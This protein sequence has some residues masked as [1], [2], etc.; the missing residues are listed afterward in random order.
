MRMKT[1]DFR[2]ATIAILLSAEAIVHAAELKVGDSAP[3]LQVAQWVQG[4]PIQNGPGTVRV[5]EFWATWCGPCK[6]SIPHLTELSKK[7]GKKV[8]FAAIDVYEHSPNDVDKVANFVRGMGSKMPFPVAVDSSQGLTA[9]AW[10]EATHQNEIPSAFVV[11]TS[12]KIVW[13]G[14][15]TNGLEEA[16]DQVLAGKF[17]L[18]G[19]EAS[20]Q[21]RVEVAKNQERLAEALDG[22]RKRYAAGHKT[23]SLAAMD[24]IAKEHPD[25]SDKVLLT[26]FDALYTD[27]KPSAIDLVESLTSKGKLVAPYLLLKMANNV[28]RRAGASSK[29]RAYCICIAEKANSLT[30]GQNP[31]I[32]AGLGQMYHAD[33]RNG[34]AI[35]VTRLAVNMLS[36]VAL[37]Q[38]SKFLELVR[39]R[40]QQYQRETIQR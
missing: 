3:L 22:E 2:R 20:F 26:K 14:C 33:H 29:D 9:K 37:N 7:Y 12:G 11:D 39:E 10:L 32:L 18:A 4:Q 17:D 30:H 1:I 23:E 8:D 15:P 35:R 31:L 21:A 36:S 40:L 27:D 34:D 13:I 28:S 25:M 38:G 6:S 24:R 16:L 5:V 19:S